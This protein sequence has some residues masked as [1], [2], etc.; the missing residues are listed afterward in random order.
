MPNLNVSVIGSLGYS[1]ELGKKST[2]TDITFYDL[3]KGDTTLTI[4]EP[5]RYPE[6][7][8]SLFYATSFPDYVI[9]IIEQMDSSFGEILLMLDT[10]GPKK[11]AII[12]RNYITIEQITRFIKNTVVENYEIL[13]DNPL[14]LRNKLIDLAETPKK[15]VALDHGTVTIDHSFNVKGIG[16]VVLGVVIDGT[17]KIHDPLRVLPSLK[18]TEVR[19][20]QKHDDDYDTA[21]KGDRVGIALKGIEVDELPRGVTLTNDPNYINSENIE[22]EAQLNQYWKIPIKEGMMVHLGYNMQFL[23]GKVIKSEPSTEQFKQKLIIKLEKPLTYIPMTK[24]ALTHLDGGKLR[25]I[26]SILLK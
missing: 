19:S 1:K 12:L 2:E 23:M 21:E 18:K 11:G 22:A 9:L 3:K 24:A 7:L 6:K 13:N 10:I 26:G 16:P 20:I 5:N 14:D 25:V 4:L 17:I 8:A 15:M